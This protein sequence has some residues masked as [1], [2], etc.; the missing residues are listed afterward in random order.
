VRHLLRCIILQSEVE[1][2]NSDELK[3]YF[4]QLL[5]NESLFSELQVIVRPVEAMIIV[6]CKQRKFGEFG[7]STKFAKANR[8]FYCSLSTV[9]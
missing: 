1:K 7:K 8:Y 2:I 4:S 9:Q 5:A 3:E 6:Y